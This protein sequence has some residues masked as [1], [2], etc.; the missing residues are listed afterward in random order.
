ML[1]EYLGVSYTMNGY[2]QH[3]LSEGKGT[4]SKAITYLS[5]GTGGTSFWGAGCTTTATRLPCARFV[6]Q[7]IIF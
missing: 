3:A 4:S 1:Q 7:S 6:R 2:E 5:I